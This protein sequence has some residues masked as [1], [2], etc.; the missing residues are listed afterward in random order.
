MGLGVKIKTLRKKENLTLQELADKAQL[1]KSNI[2]D[3]ENEKRFKPNIKTLEKIAKALNCEVGDFFE[4]SIDREEEMTK[5]LRDLLADEKLITLL[6]I[7]NDELEWMKT[8]RFRIDHIPT[9]DTY[10]DILYTYRKIEKKVE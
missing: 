9:K 2:S 1:Y 6:K 5:G 3:I 10:I 7:T 8:I 4:R